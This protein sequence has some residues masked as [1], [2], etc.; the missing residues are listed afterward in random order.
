MEFNLTL[1]SCRKNDSDDV[2]FIAE[3]RKLAIFN[4]IIS[5]YIFMRSGHPGISDDMDTD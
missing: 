1:L 2:L 5:L 4:K 3:I